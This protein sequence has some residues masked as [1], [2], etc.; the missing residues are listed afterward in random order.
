[1]LHICSPKFLMVILT[2]V[3]KVRHSIIAGRV[4]SDIFQS[5]LIMAGNFL[6]EG[7]AEKRNYVII[8]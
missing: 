8:I 4:T 5:V 3:E 1:M 2:V 6:K 7:C